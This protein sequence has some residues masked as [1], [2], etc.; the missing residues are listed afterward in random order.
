MLCKII[1]GV[2]GDQALP[3]GF[4]H[5]VRVAGTAALAGAVVIKQGATTLET[6]PIGTAVGVERDY[7]TGPAGTRMDSGNGGVATINMASAADS[8]LVFY[9]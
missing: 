8:V 5:R 6:L 3:Q 9:S 2:T 4:L 1:T 7:G